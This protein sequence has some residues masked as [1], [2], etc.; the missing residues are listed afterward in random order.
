MI[1]IAKYLWFF[2]FLTFFLWAEAKIA[3]IFEVQYALR[4]PPNPNIMRH[5][6][7]GALENWPVRWPVI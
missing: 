4:Y 1:M 7:Y 2:Q 3:F 5:I 6:R